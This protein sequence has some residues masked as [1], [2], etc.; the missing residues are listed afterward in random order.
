MSDKV[1]DSLNR[2]LSST[3]ALYLKT[4]NYHWNVTGAHF[5]DLHK[6]FETQYVSLSEAIDS[7]AEHIRSNGH[8]AP[9]TFKIYSSLSVVD[10]G[11]EELAWKEMVQDLYQSHL[12]IVKLLEKG[13]EITLKANDQVI[14]DL[15]IQRL[16]CHKKD[17]WMLKAILG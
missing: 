17:A 14:N 15:Y 9:A 16:S 13:L 8:K 7:I 12:L 5:H 11:N 2:V 4:Q 6:L 1:I 10:D 3:Y